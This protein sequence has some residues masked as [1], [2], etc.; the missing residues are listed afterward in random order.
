[1][2]MDK[3]PRNES[4]L[5][6]RR[7]F[8]GQTGSGL[9]MVGGA[10]ACGGS[11]E[12]Q[13]SSPHNVSSPPAQYRLIRAE[14]THREMGRQHGEQASDQIRTHVDRM[15]R[16]REEL[17][18]QASRFKPLFEKHCP[19]LLDE[20]T[21]LAEGARITLA[22]AL[23]VNIRGELR[24]ASAEGCTTYVIGRRGTAN[25]EIL[26]GQNSD[27]GQQSIDLGYILHLK[28]KD[29]PQV[30]I[31]TFGGMI[32]YHGMNSAGVAIFE[33]ALSERG[34]VPPG[35]FAM[36]HYPVK[37][38]ILESS[39]IEAAL[40]L[41]RRIPLA[42]NKNYVICDGSGVILDI[43]STTAGPEL[44]RDEGAGFLAHSNHF[45]CSKY[46]NKES[47]DDALLPDSRKRFHRINEL[48][49]ADFGSIT[50]DRMKAHLSDHSDH[51][52]SICRH[53]QAAASGSMKTVASMIAEP[54]FRRM[55]VALGN[56]CN[57]RYVTYSM[58]A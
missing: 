33:N 42:S 19:H 54:A 6:N 28:P 58:D 52:T 26:I 17:K 43:E 29:K 49:R 46:A 55:Q 36:P 51:P 45:V 5:P 20:I 24:K 27:M 56:P 12:A 44:L 10:M 41:F 39:S 23:A 32:G 21:G 7:Q 11:M 4:G 57:S 13:S 8:L 9:I 37:R 16:S 48:I 38:M 47:P 50:V 40:G 3:Q 34:A 15:A 53:P 35:R 22:E 25:R 1:M 31:W 14:G 2:A 18:A 30:L